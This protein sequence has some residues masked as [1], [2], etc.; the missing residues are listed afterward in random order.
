MKA[1]RLLI[2]FLNTVAAIALLAAFVSPMVSPAR[3]PFLS[4]IGLT[5]PYLLIVNLLFMLFWIA[6]A[7]LYF[8]I[9]LITMIIS[10]SSVKTS[11]PYHNKKNKIEQ[12]G[13]SVMSYNVRVFDRYNWTKDSNNVSQMLSF[14]KDENPDIICMQEFGSSRKGLT[15][16]SILNALGKYPYHYISYSEATR[17]A[18]HRQGLAILSKYPISDKRTDPQIHLADGYTTSCTI[19]VKDQKYQIINAYFSPIKVINKYDFIG[20]L[21]SKNYKVNVRKAIYSVGK[22]SVQHT[23]HAQRIKEIVDSSPYPT[24]LCSDMN[25]SPIS[26]SYHTLTH[27]LD[28][29]Y[30]HYGTGFG[31]TYNGKYPFLRIDYILHNPNLTLLSYKRIKTKH[32]D[33]FPIIATFKQ[34]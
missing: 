14:I 15:E 12:E 3:I 27:F 22:A 29:A 28:D 33:H 26:H 8:L 25:S 7:R 23:E 32:S 20:G 10:W 5:M 11:F 34:D 16:R 31:A 17:A 1:I 13:F 6:K 24:I 2:I 30:L 19:K 4:S 18:K 9:S 21:D